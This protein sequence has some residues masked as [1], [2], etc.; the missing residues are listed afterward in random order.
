MSDALKLLAGDAGDVSVI[1]AILQDAIV[2]V[3][4]MRYEPEQGR[5]ILAA[6][7]FCWENSGQPKPVYERV[8]CAMIVHGVTAV[9]TQQ[10]DLSARDALHDLLAVI[11]DGKTLKLIF[12]GDMMIKL[13][14]A[15]WQIKLEDFGAPWPT[16][17]CPRH[18]QE[19]DQA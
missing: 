18:G 2:A 16:E 6:S 11:L 7:R 4:D 5:F 12:A 14:C 9:Q 8:N 10:L 13:H 15:D 3:R 19:T 1:S 17:A